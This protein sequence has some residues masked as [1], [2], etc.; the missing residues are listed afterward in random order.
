MDISL[1]IERSN[2]IVSNRG[3]NSGLLRR[4][5]V[6]PRRRLRLSPVQPPVPP[7]STRPAPQQTPVP[8]DMIFAH[9]SMVSLI[10]H[11]GNKS[12][13]AN[14]EGPMEKLSKPS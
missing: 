8:N 7:A 14:Y 9:H 5:S 12:L 10:I 13:I 11:F 4:Q 6:A 3:E 1:A 2:V